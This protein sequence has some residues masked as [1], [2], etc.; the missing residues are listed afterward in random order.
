[1]SKSDPNSGIFI[2]NTDD[3]IKKKINKAWCD[4]GILENNP[5][6]AIAESIIFSKFNEIAIERPEKFGGNITYANYIDLEND[7]KE[8]KL[9]P[10]DLKQ[11]VGNYLVKIV[12]P[13]REKLNLSDE[14][15]EA[16][17]KSF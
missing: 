9:H 10:G 1:M 17:K 15:S 4:E 3:E 12:S 11:T 5:I 8:K 14:L 16:I 7:F 2:H 6:L 13:I